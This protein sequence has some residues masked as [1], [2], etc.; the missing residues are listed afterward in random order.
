MG[1]RPAD[2]ICV[3]EIGGD[4]KVFAISFPAPSS[5]LKRLLEDFFLCG[6]SIQDY[7][8]L[9][10]VQFPGGEE[11]KI[12]YRV[13]AESAVVKGNRRVVYIGTKLSHSVC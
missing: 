11:V 5:L 2:A 1:P 3:V 12:F 10:R 13:E 4:A 9:V 8:L 6:Y 7:G